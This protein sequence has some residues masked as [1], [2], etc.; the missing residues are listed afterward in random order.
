MAGASLA[1]YSRC[2]QETGM[3]VFGKTLF[4]TVLDAIE[5]EESDEDED[6]PLRRPRVVAHFLADTSFSERPEDRPLG[7]LY[8]D[9]GEPAAIEPERPE[10]PKPPTWLD[11]LSEQDVATDLGLAS[12]MTKAEIREKRRAFARISHPDGVAEE[13][14]EAATIRMTI[15]NRLVEVALRHAAG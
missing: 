1:R 7:E 15:A 11:R 10:A 6:V 2:E 9:F 8:E 14:R 3:P 5:V 13:F 4:E 12:G